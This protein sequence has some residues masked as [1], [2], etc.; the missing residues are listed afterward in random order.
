VASSVRE[1]KPELEHEERTARTNP[2]A[3]DR[4]PGLEEAAADAQQDLADLDTEYPGTLL[5]SPELIDLYKEVVQL[6]EAAAARAQA[7]AS[8]RPLPQWPSPGKEA[9]NWSVAG[10]L[11][12]A[13]IMD[14]Y[15]RFSLHGLLAYLSRIDGRRAARSREL[16]LYCGL[17]GGDYRLQLMLRVERILNRTGLSIYVSTTLSPIS[18]LLYPFRKRKS[19]RSISRRLTR[20]HEAGLVADP[21][22]RQGPR[23]PVQTSCGARW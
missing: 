23:R 11:N 7:R 8:N 22:A 6:E 14:R 13:R 16:E 2:G 10:A 19:A 12:D 1:N 3:P 21:T 15:V 20:A 18:P 17:L 5:P 9:T 4:Q